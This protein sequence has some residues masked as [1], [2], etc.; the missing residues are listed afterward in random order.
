ME[1]QPEQIH[2]T[3]INIT[4]AGTLSNP[5][6]TLDIAALLTEKNKAKIEKFVEKNL[7]KID[8]IV[9][10]ID[11]KLGPKVGDLLKGLFKKHKA[12]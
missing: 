9:E 1:P 12:E 11:K 8:N 3:P 7:E 5:T 6:Y 2:D 4:V 10:K